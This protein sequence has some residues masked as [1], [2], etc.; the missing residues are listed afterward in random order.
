MASCSLESLSSGKFFSKWQTLLSRKGRKKPLDRVWTRFQNR[1]NGKH[2]GICLWSPCHRLFNGSQLVAT[3]LYFDAK[4]QSLFDAKGIVPSIALLKSTTQLII[5]NARL[6]GWRL[7][8]LSLT[9]NVNGYAGYGAPARCMKV[10]AEYCT[11]LLSVL[12]LK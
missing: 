11:R 9:F 6:W 7:G 4:P 5:R 10:V 12:D 1:L 2:E 8:S 3:L